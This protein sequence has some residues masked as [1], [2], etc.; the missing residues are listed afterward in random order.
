MSDTNVKNIDKN[1]FLFIRQIND[2]ENS[3][4][5]DQYASDDEKK[6]LSTL[7]TTQRKKEWLT[8]RHLLSEACIKF[9]L[10]YCPV[11]KDNHGK[12]YLPGFDGG[13][14]YTHSQTQAGLLIHPHASV[15]IDIEKPR[16][17]LFKVKHK[18]LSDEELECYDND[19]ELMTIAWSAKE[20]IYKAYGRK[21]LS[22]K[23]NIDLLSINYDTKIIET[24]IIKGDLK[25]KM[26][27]HFFFSNDEIVTYTIRENPTPF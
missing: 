15:G 8:I 5:I 25:E 4:E 16:E 9:K 11:I 2:M 23:D 7:K 13:I 24:R 3:F 19:I 6:V 26:K 27:V 1:S 10:D 14:S 17:K 22:L 21:N 12:P 20:S 18:F